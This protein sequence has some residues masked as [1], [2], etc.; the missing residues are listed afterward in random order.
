MPL[1]IQKAV[2]AE[3]YRLLKPGGYILMA[4]IKAYHVQKPYE[5]WKAD[6]WNYVHGGDRFWRDYAT[7]DQATSR[8]AAEG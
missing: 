2:L 5:R 7:T 6:F 4:D 3:A 8:V 1:D